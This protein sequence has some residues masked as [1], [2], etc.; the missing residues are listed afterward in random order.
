MLQF[1]MCKN[2]FTKFISCSEAQNSRSRMSL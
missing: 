2:N 1:S